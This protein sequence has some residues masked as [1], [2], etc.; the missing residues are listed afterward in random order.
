MANVYNIRDMTR[1]ATDD[2]LSMRNCEGCDTLFVIDLCT[3]M[4][5][6]KRADK[7]TGIVVRTA[8]QPEERPVADDVEQVRTATTRSR[9]GGG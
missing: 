3:R 8:I 6:K 7:G 9:P 2:D 4:A 5:N 1:S